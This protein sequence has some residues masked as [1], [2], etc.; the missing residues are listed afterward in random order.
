MW[1]HRS[2]GAQR[3]T[4]VGEGCRAGGHLSWA[5][6]TE[7]ECA[8]QRGKCSAVERQDGKGE[9]EVTLVFST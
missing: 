1:G 3:C 2:V 9:S 5:W 4:Q 8:R 6:Q 7:E